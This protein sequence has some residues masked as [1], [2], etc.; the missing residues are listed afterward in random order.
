MSPN[1]LH[2]G[3][4]V[5]YINARLLDP[6]TG[7]DA[8]GGVLTEGETITQVGAGLFSDSVPEDAKVHDVPRQ[9]HLP[10]P[11]RHAHAHERRKRPN[12]RGRTRRPPASPRRC[13]RRASSR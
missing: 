6:A 13:A 10:R 11:G 12:N 2:Q 4:K 9:M 5:A 1:R 3:D 7:L 8:L